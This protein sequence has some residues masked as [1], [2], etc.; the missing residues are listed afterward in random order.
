MLKNG[1]MPTPWRHPKHGTYYLKKRVPQAIKH[2]WTGTDPVQVSLNTKN[3]SEAH[4]RICKVWL[5]LRRKF[6]DLEKLA[7]RQA[8]LSEAL[9]P[10]LLEEWL[11]DSLAQD[12]QQRILG[13]IPRAPDSTNPGYLELRD[14]LADG[15]ESGKHPEFLIREAAWLLNGKGIAF[16]PKSYAFAKLLHELSPLY[17]RYLN[18]LIARD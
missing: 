16:D 12:E 13:Q 6:E 15:D 8:P 10:H 14:A 7:A 18:T 1:K 2:L 17:C 11:H 3:A 9:I 5:D 4:T